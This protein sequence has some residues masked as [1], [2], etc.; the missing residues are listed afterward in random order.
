[1]LGLSGRIRSL[2]DVRASPQGP[3]RII[4]RHTRAVPTRLD[5]AMPIRSGEIVTALLRT[6]RLVPSDT[7]PGQPNDSVTERERFASETAFRNRELTTK[8][9]EIEFKKLEYARSRWTNP[10]VVVI[11]AAALAAAGNILVAYRTASSALESLDRKAEADRI[12][13]AI[14]PD[15]DGAKVH[16]LQ[17]LGRL[18]LVSNQEMLEATKRFVNDYVAQSAPLPPPPPTNIAACK[19]GLTKS[20]SL[21]NT[22][23]LDGSGNTVGIIGPMTITVTQ[24]CDSGTPGP[25]HYTASYRFYNGSG[26]QGGSQT[27]SLFFKS[28]N[29][30]VL[31]PPPPV[32]FPLIRGR[33]IYGGS[34]ARSAEGVLSADGRLIAAVTME[35]SRVKGTQTPC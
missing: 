21:P 1:M 10:L 15:D 29:G 17:F 8:E 3:P 2:A 32:T 34:E 33:C 27:V 4:E 35:I 13:E 12:L 22:P 14:K 11:F 9:K 30:A 20:F 23:T 31:Q 24:K 19:D 28:E 18:K 7:P 25:F 16:R 5:F 6:L 26:T